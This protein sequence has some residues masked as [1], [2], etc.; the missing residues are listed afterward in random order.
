MRSH[1][2]TDFPDPNPGGGFGAPTSEL[3]NNPHFG[4]AN[5]ACH[6]LLPNGGAGGN[7]KVRQNLSQLLR[8]AQCMRSHGVPNYPDP[9]PN[10]APV[11]LAQLGINE[12][13][14]Q[15]QSAQRTCERLYPPPSVPPS[16][17]GGS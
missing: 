12:N 1:G 3:L 13:S 5:S 2:V 7:N 4:T 17:G 16:H 15:F 14:P 6:H 8:L 9:N 11:N 10:N